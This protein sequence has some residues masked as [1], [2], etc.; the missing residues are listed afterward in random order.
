[1]DP[2]IPD[3]TIPLATTWATKKADLTLRPMT[4]SN[5]SSVTSQKCSGMLLPALLTRM[6][7]GPNFFKLLTASI[8]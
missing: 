5:L 1:M 4:L 6:L 3:S 2:L 7:K 8:E